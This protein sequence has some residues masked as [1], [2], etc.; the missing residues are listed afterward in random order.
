LCA[1]RVGRCRRQVRGA[2]HVGVCV[3]RFRRAWLTVVAGCVGASLPLT[4]SAQPLLADRP[5]DLH[6]GRLI[7]V[8][9]ICI[10]LAIA[11][12]ILLKRATK[13]RANILSAPWL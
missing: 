6:I 11:A 4:A 5:L 9:V 3:K 10:A 8:L 1:W 2:H 7:L 12:A 13:G